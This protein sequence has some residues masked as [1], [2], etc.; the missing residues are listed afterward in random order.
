MSAADL[1]AAGNYRDHHPAHHNEGAQ[2]QQRQQQQAFLYEPPRVGSPWSE[3][4]SGAWTGTRAAAWG[5][6]GGGGGPYDDNQVGFVDSSA[7]D[8][9]YYY[10][11]GG[12]VP[13]P[14]SHSHPAPAPGYGDLGSPYEDRGHT[15]QVPAVRVH[16]PRWEPAAARDPD[17]DLDMDLNQDQDQGRQ[18][19][20]RGSE[21][22]PQRDAARVSRGLSVNDEV[23][24][25]SSTGSGMPYPRV[26]AISGMGWE[27]NPRVSRG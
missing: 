19:Q 3:W 13:L 7:E 4:D 2:Q 6:G 18:G 15:Y 14:V 17:P 22:P 5:G 23:S 1:A 8:Q 12:H 9:R 20:G 16:G 25:L 10:Y 24:P 26:S 11:P 27:T 21:R